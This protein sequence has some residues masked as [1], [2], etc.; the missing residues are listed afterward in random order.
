MSEREKET[1][2]SRAS[3]EVDQ[4]SV[5]ITRDTVKRDRD[6]QKQFLDGM[7]TQNA[8]LKPMQLLG[9]QTVQCSQ[10]RTQPCSA[11]LDNTGYQ[12]HQQM[13]PSVALQLC[14]QSPVLPS[15]S[16]GQ[17]DHHYVGALPIQDIQCTWQL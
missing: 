6:T 10:S 3:I 15:P 2:V 16:T 5:A 11:A 9:L 7:Q 14:S 12:E 4:G 13:F 17:Q 1:Q 8:L